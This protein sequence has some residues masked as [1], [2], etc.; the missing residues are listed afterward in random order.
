MLNVFISE[1]INDDRETGR[2]MKRMI[3]SKAELICTHTHTDEKYRQAMSF[4]WK[5]NQ[6]L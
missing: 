5:A 3:E 6:L 1:A 4:K 2:E